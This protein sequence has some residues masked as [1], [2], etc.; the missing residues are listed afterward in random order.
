MS[1]LLTLQ[2]PV[3]VELGLVLAHA[4][5]QGAAIAMGLAV[6]LRLLGRWSADVRYGACGVALVLMAMCP[7]LT[8]AYLRIAPPGILNRI[9]VA[10]TEASASVAPV[11]PSH[12]SSEVPTGTLDETRRDGIVLSPPDAA[13]TISAVGG[14]GDAFEPAPQ[15]EPAPGLIDGSAI[16]GLLPRI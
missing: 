10:S 15:V 8:F 3:W 7:I 13:P 1:E 11:S 6:V 16:G 14:V 12:A 9:L 5:W 4:V 2:G